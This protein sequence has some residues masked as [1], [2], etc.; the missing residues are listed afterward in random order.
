MDSAWLH[1]NACGLGGG[2]CLRAD[3]FL[4]VLRNIYPRGLALRNRAH[5]LPE[6]GGDFSLRQACWHGAHLPLLPMLSGQ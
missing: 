3:A 6:S 1:R 2:N 4:R 5:Y